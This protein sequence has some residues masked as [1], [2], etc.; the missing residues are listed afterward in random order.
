M[1][2]EENVQVPLVWVGVEELPLLSV[3]QILGQILG[4]DEFLL[5]FGQVAPPILLGTDEQKRDQARMLTFAAIKPVARLAMTR[6]RIQELRDLLDRQ[7]EAHDKQ[8]GES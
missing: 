3:N 5:A 7:I 1:A 4:K 2:D 6:Q 8:H